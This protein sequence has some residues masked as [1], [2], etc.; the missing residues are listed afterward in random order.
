MGVHIFSSRHQVLRAIDIR[1][2]AERGI[3]RTLY[4]MS[5]VAF[6]CLSIPGCSLSDLVDVDTP[7]TTITPIQVSTPA[8]ALGLYSGTIQLFNLAYGA[9]DGDVILSGIFTDEFQDT[10]A[11]RNRIDTRELTN[12]PRDIRSVYNRLQQVRTQG[13][14]TVVAMRKFPD[15][16]PSPLIGRAYA[17]VGYAELLLAERFCS[18]IPLP[19]IPAGGGSI[20]YSAGLSTSALL[21]RAIAHFDSALAFIGADSLRFQSLARVGKGRA[22]LGLNRYDDAA[23]A[24]SVVSTDFVY[25][26]EFS[27][28]DTNAVR[29]QTGGTLFTS[30]TSEGRNGIDWLTAQDPR[31]PIRDTVKDLVRSRKYATSTSPIVIADGIEAR[32]IEAEALLANENPNWLTTLNTLRARLTLPGGARALADTTDPGTSAA[33]VD[34]LFRE[35]AF[36]LYATGHR[37]GD[38]RRLVRQYGRNSATVF[39]SGPYAPQFLNAPPEYVPN[40][41]FQVPNDNLGERNPHYKG[42]YDFNA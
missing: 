32:L 34:L 37:H 15:A 19:V 6:C 21:T 13:L 23:S 41:V 28:T 29:P 25:N 42:C 38:L 5:I 2:G 1:S 11:L 3:F 36:W 18:G 12:D 14:Q 31:V 35:R 24:V 33:R 4:R 22:L 39:P 30:N 26:A 40:V 9:V 20:T 27:A 17:I 7:N 10:S 8:G 16:I